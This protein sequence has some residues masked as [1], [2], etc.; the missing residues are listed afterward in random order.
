MGLF[1][2][3]ARSPVDSDSNLKL[4]FFERARRLRFRDGG[5]GTAPIGVYSGGRFVACV[6]STT[7]CA[8]SALAVMA[9]R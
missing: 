8:N 7:F 3:N 4:V 9:S 1:S 2:V 5:S 6:M